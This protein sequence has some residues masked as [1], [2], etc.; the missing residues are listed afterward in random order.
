MGRTLPF[1]LAPLESLGLG[2]AQGISVFAASSCA[3]RL[4]SVNA[5]LQG[6]RDRLF[7]GD[8]PS[9]VDIQL[10]K[11]NTLYSQ[12][13]EPTSWDTDYQLASVRPSRNLFADP[14]TGSSTGAELG[15]GGAAQLYGRA[16]MQA[17]FNVDRD[18]FSNDDYANGDSSELAARGLYGSYQILFPAGVLS[19]AGGTGLDLNAIDDILLRLDY[20]SVAR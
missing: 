2:E 6:Q 17:F 8:D 1:E 19:T 14:G 18:E 13:S 3:E 9:F 7:V 10:L 11:Q 16:R 15:L 5:T 20:V 12:W 4:W